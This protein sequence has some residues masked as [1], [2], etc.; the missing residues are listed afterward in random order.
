MKH[1]IQPIINAADGRI[2]FK[3]NEIVRYLLDT[4]PTV[5]M[6]SIAGMEF[7]DDDRQQ[8]AQLIG[9]SLSGYGDL[10]YVDDTAYEA[11]EKMGQEDCHLCNADK[12]LMPNI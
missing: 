7:T 10:S 9:Y 3:A 4:H 11:A 8:F 5:D 12:L 6:N 2:R 1:P